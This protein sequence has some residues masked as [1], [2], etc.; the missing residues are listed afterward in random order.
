MV[1]VKRFKLDFLTRDNIVLFK[2]EASVLRRLSHPNVIQF[3]GVVI[4]PPCMA[5]VMAH[6]TRGDLFTHLR[7]LNRALMNARRSSSL[8]GGS[9]NG[10]GRA[11]WLAPSVDGT[12]SFAQSNA[13]SAQE[14]SR[15]SAAASG[16]LGGGGGGASVARG[17]LL[18]IG[19]S[20]CPL[21]CALDVAMGMKYLHSHGMVHCDLKLRPRIRVLTGRR[22]CCSGSAVL[23]CRI[24][25][26]YF[27]S[28]LYGHEFAV[29]IRTGCDFLEAQLRLFTLYSCMWS[30]ALNSPMLREFLRICADGDFI[31]WVF[32]RSLPTCCW[33]PIGSL[34]SPI[35]ATSAKQLFTLR[36]QHLLA[37]PPPPRGLQALL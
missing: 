9:T 10:N 30:F 28:F 14:S 29:R 32:L 7:K 20:F 34:K 4:D 12:N 37:R 21:K 36:R 11:P 5:I 26:S 18:E 6:G 27:S 1:V 13:S 17:S 24:S 3:Y 25:M 8:W 19:S 15:S 31:T 23:V 22:V 16:I 2:K 35:S 33:T